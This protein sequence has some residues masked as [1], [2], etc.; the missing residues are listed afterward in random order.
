MFQQE[1]VINIYR[2]RKTG[3][4]RIQPFARAT[5]SSQPFGEQT[6]IEA[7]DAVTT[8]LDAVLHNLAKNAS[9]KYIK[10]LMPRISDEEFRRSLKEDQL[11]SVSRFQGKYRIMPFKRMRSSMGSIDE[12]EVSVSEE[13]FLQKGTELIQ[14]AFSQ[15]S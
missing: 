12:L 4:F 14:E 13:E 10:E 5:H 1:D 2:N 11:V 3:Q 9:Q 7:Q 8:L 6:T 15:I